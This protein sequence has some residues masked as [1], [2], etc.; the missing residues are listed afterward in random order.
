MPESRLSLDC[1]QTLYG[2]F[3]VSGSILRLTLKTGLEGG[4]D[5]ELGG[6]LGSVVGGLESESSED[7]VE[8]GYDSF[9]S[10]NL[11]E[12]EGPKNPDTAPP[13][14]GLSGWFRWCNVPGLGLRGPGLLQ[15][16]EILLCDCLDDDM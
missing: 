14:R 7:F 10:E 3:G 5:C 9:C 2:L 4:G 6:G 16:D 15:G 13:G 1:C 8:L 11:R 12:K